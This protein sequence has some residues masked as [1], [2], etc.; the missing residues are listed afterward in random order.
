M[1]SIAEEI[2]EELKQFQTDS[3]RIVRYLGICVL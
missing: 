1:G 3:D 2:P